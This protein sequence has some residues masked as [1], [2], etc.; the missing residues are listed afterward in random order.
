MSPP[1]ICGN[2]F[3]TRHSDVGTRAMVPSRREGMGVMD[4]WVALNER[5]RAYLQA[6]YAAVRK[7]RRKR[8][9]FGPSVRRAALRPRGAGRAMPRL[10]SAP[11]R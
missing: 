3:E 11:P 6:I 1:R 10:R 2:V 5:Q 8:G 9:R 7:R 4:E